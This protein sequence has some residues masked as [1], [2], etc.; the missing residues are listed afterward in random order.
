MVSNY[1]TGRMD[2]ENGETK[3]KLNLQVYS[4]RKGVTDLANG[5]DHFTKPRHS[6]T[7][8]ELHNHTHKVAIRPYFKIGPNGLAVL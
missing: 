2:K 8:T 5:I 1:T 3:T 4:C 6:K 7:E